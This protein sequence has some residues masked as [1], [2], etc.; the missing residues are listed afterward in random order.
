[1]ANTVK[2][3]NYYDHQFLRAP[4]FS[5]EQNYHLSMRRQHN[6]LLHTS[7]VA[8]GL[9]ATAAAGGTVVNVTAGVAIDSNGREI[10]LP[11]DVQ[12]D[13]SGEAVG[14]TVFLTIEYDEQQ[15]DASTEVGGLGN[16]RW[17]ETPKVSF[18]EQAPP[19]DSTKL[20]L[21]SVTR[22]ATGLGPID[23]TV[24]KAAGVVVA[25]DLSVNS[26]T[27][28]RDGVD[29]TTWPKLSCSGPNQAVVNGN[30]GFGSAPPNHNLTV[31]AVG[32]KSCGD[33]R[34]RLRRRFF[35]IFAHEQNLPCQIASGTAEGLQ[36][37]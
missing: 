35:Q 6:G 15:S 16:T 10:V 25:G 30:I 31:S 33:P 12:L 27:L 3:L 4:D 37:Y 32:L 20:V 14:T 24:R 21:G 9:D 13:L 19:V 2:R 34:A 17:T 11:G 22:T 23:T 26:V 7:G 28:K 8:Q 1:M 5:D 29:P 36:I 18:A